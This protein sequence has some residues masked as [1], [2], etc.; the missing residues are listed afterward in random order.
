MLTATIRKVETVT[1]EVSG[2]GLPEVREKL[3]AECPEG[4]ELIHAPVA[5]QKGSTAITATARYARRDGLREVTGRTVEE[6][7][8][9][10]PD[11]WQML[12]YLRD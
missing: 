10:V 1:I 3:A 8:A 9:A 5:M 11:G 7:R 6:L 2:E 12:Y 4:F